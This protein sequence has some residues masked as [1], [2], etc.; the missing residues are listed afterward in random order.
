MSLLDCTQ[1]LFSTFPCFPQ[2]SL[3]CKVPHHF[4]LYKLC[5]DISI[6][7]RW[8]SVSHPQKPTNLI[9]RE[10]PFCFYTRCNKHSTLI[11]LRIEITKGRGLQGP[12]L[13]PM[14]ANYSH[15]IFL[16][17]IWYNTLHKDVNGKCGGLNRSH[18]SP[19]DRH[20][21]P[22]CPVIWI[23]THKQFFEANLG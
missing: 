4:G 8:H 9:D 7:H 20:C 14:K 6:K 11:L 15:K 23:L 19:V 1:K 18:E 5:R 12:E 3:A 22:W 21:N 17:E 10:V 13:E 16:H 2:Y